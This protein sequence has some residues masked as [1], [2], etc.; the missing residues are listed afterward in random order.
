MIY[1]H[2]YYELFT[3]KSDSFQFFFSTKG[4]PREAE[5]CFFLKSDVSLIQKNYTKWIND[6]TFGQ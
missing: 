2:I 6:A 4:L 3:L 5:Q 1:T